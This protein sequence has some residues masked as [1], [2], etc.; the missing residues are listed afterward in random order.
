[1][2]IKYIEYKLYSGKIWDLKELKSYLLKYIQKQEK[3]L[4]MRKF[5]NFIISY[6]NYY[7]WKTKMNDNYILLQLTEKLLNIKQKERRNKNTSKSKEIFIKK[8]EKE[9][10]K[11]NILGPIELNL[12]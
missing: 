1:M 8:L 11:L 7:K 6:F 5:K 12:Q 9:I 2:N 4:Y 3:T 10:Y